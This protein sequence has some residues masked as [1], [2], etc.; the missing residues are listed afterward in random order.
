MLQ[1]SDWVTG[2][3]L[4][5]ERLIGFVEEIGSDGW[6]KV[7]VT[8]SDHEE[9]VSS[10]IEVKKSKVRKLPEQ[11][12]NKEDARALIELALET[13]DRAWFDE[14]QSVQSSG[15]SVS[16]DRLKGYKTRV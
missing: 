12:L 15:P 11:G 3:T 16:T 6:V 9:I 4:E 10:V 1:V 2:T 13:H 14:L 5:D 7:W 8:Q